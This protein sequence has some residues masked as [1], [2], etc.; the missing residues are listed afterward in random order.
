MRA[1]VYGFSLWQKLM[2]MYGCSS[3]KKSVSQL[4]GRFGDLAAG[5]LLRQRG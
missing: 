1:L 4:C 2:A 3:R 5:T